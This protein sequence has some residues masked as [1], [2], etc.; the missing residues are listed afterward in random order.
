[1]DGILP[2]S[3]GTFTAVANKNNVHLAWDTYAETNNNG[4]YIERSNDGSTFEKIGFVKGKGN[5]AVQTKYAFINN[6]PFDGLNYYRLKQTDIDGAFNYSSVRSVNFGSKALVVSL[7]PNPASNLLTLDGNGNKLNGTLLLV[8]ATGRIVLESKV[9]ATEVHQV[10][11]SK[12]SPGIY[13]YRIN[14]FKGTF[15]KR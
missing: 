5:S 3:L 8:D 11:I 10:N 13:F 4:F 1:M 12:L 9:V 15:I 14:E 2:V 7:Y 6:A